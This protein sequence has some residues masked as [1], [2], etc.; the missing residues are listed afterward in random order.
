M[1]LD[2]DS[3]KQWLLAHGEKV[4]LAVVG[5]IA[6]LMMVFAFIG[7]ESVGPNQG[8]QEI[9]KR[10]EDAKSKLL[11]TPAPTVNV[12]EPTPLPPPFHVTIIPSRTPVAGALIPLKRVRREPQ[13]VPATDIRAQ[14]VRG[15][16]GL[17][18]GK[19]EDPG[20]AD[21]LKGF[22]G[23]K[24]AEAFRVAV[25][26]GLVPLGLQ[27][28]R[29]DEAFI[30]T[31]FYEGYTGAQDRPEYYRCIL[32]RAEVKPGM[33]DDQLAWAAVGEADSEQTTADVRDPALKTQMDKWAGVI[34][35]DLVDQSLVERWLVYPNAR[36]MA[37]EADASAAP[38][39]GDETIDQW[40][41]P[42]LLFDW[43]RETIVHP[44]IAAAQDEAVSGAKEKPEETKTNVIKPAVKE[45]EGE[46]TEKIKKFAA[47]YGQRLLRCYDFSVEPGKNYKYRVIL[48]LQ[49]PNR[50][51]DDKYLEN[52]KLKEGKFRLAAASAPSPVVSSPGDTQVLAGPGVAPTVRQREPG[53]KLLLT[54]LA[55]TKEAVDLAAAAAANA[56]GPI[57]I[58]TQLKEEA[59]ALAVAWANV[60]KVWA[61]T[62]QTGTRGMFLSKQGN[63]TAT[64][65]HPVGGINTDLK[66]IP[67]DT[68]NCLV[69]FVGGPKGPAPKTKDA[70]EQAIEPTQILLLDSNGRLVIRHEAE[71]RVA[72]ERQTPEAAAPPPEKPAE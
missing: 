66:V 60:D 35:P 65:K 11:T 56:R 9:A 32:E 70:K 36:P 15:H 69:D 72:Y 34:Q 19:G 10:A 67:F 30:D 37:E 50:G 29:Y 24:Q 52:P 12:P 51:F 59:D 47:S 31:T 46:D 63:G 18:G 48:V 40:L 22:K 13:F 71:D 3:I 68:G 61:T 17:K 33:T 16:M 53:V 45:E 55:D 1:K 41:P 42:R 2:G 7:K 28:I 58:R 20:A 44:T 25:V 57:K 21:D 62:E 23:A 6:L 39:E 26:T 27:R 49:N 8:P 14:I 64:I 54:V 5:T 43:E 38:A 4:I